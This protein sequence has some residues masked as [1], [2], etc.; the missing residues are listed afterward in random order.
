MRREERREERCEERPEDEIV[1]AMFRNYRHLT[2]QEL[3]EFQRHVI[4]R[5]KAKR[6]EAIRGMVRALAAWFRRRAA[7]ARLQRLDDR[8]LKDI[9]LHRS[10]IDAVVSGRHVPYQRQTSTLASVPSCGRL[11]PTIDPQKPVK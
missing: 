7:V 9:G 6:A 2:P 4:E 8:M 5:A 1:D 3:S 11:Q 10:E